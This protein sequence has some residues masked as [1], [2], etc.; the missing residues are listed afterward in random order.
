MTPPSRAPNRFRW[1]PLR[2][3]RA[4]WPRDDAGPLSVVA[5]NGRRRW[6]DFGWR[7]YAAAPDDP[8]V[9]DA[10]IAMPYP[11]APPGALTP[12]AWIATW[13]LDPSPAKHGVLA[14]ADSAAMLPWFA[15]AMLALAGTTASGIL[16]AGGLGL[17]GLLLRHAARLNECDGDR[18][19]NIA[20][21]GRLWD[22]LLA[23]PSS[24]YARP[25]TR[26]AVDVDQAIAGALQLAR[27]RRVMTAPALALGTAGIVLGW[28]SP[29]MVGVAA[30]ALAVFAATIWWLS[31]R[32]VGAT[33]RTAMAAAG[34]RRDVGFAARY[35]PRLR[36]LGVTQARRL[37]LDDLAAATNDAADEVQ[38]ARQAGD[39]VRR[40]GMAVSAI[41]VLVSIPWFDAGMTTREI[42]A[43]LLLMPV[44]AVA[45][46]DLASAFGQRAELV[47]SIAAIDDLLGVDLDPDGGA[48]NDI[49]TVSL[50]AVTYRH[51]AGPEVLTDVNLTL[52]RGEVIALS[53]SS[54]AGKSTLLRIVMGLVDPS[55]GEVFVNGR[56]LRAAQAAS[57]R[58]R[59]ACVFQNEDFGFATVRNAVCAGR[60]GVSLPDAEAALADVGLLDDV[61]ALPMGL[62]TLVIAGAF[63]L[64]FC[65][66]LMIARSLAANAD[67]L[68]FDETLTGLDP[69]V[70]R[71]I[72]D[73]ARRRGAAVVFSTHKP[74]LLGYADRILRLPSSSQC[75]E[76][77]TSISETQ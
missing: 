37:Q 74:A 61:L 53:G 38:H 32:Q 70:A 69:A 33:R 11:A 36:D 49:Q 64:S 43:A 2:M 28:I 50:N 56:R 16:L 4:G 21:H 71:R 34:F 5:P 19:D 62:Q 9:P 13:R 66:R 54:G 68:V 58:A 57:F 47:R 17:S 29:T 46:A 27:L 31:G 22:R 18:S 30:P 6:I 52:R 77:D 45:T 72:L 63:P 10:G 65:H 14:L 20:V 8:G 41:A 39:A 55:S 40:L 15:P 48:C 51:N 59:I 12:R 1:R 7:R 60:T 73:A 67:M 26:L 35:L 76:G 75:P 44:A 42:V 24:L 3:P 25:P 23:L